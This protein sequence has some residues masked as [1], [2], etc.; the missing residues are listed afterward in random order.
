MLEGGTVT[1]QGD[2]DALMGQAGTYAHLFS[3]QAAGYQ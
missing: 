1:E 3:L 2:H